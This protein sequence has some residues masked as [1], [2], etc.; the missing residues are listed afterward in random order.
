MSSRALQGLIAIQNFR[1]GLVLQ[2]F[3]GAYQN[4]TCNFAKGVRASML[5][6]LLEYYRG[7]TPKP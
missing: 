6:G 3:L 4:S 2:G 5:A 1:A 7:Q